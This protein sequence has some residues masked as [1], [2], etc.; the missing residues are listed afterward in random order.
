[1]QNYVEADRA[2]NENRVVEYNN[3]QVL[4]RKDESPYGF[5]RLSLERGRLPEYLLGV[6]TSPA[7]A[8][9]AALQYLKTKPAK[10]SE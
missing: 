3:S 10:T 5:W 7:Q 6:Y 8:S 9:E 4:V 1:M 2:T